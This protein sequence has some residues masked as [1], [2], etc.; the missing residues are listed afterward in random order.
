M[1]PSALYI[2]AGKDS[3]ILSGKVIR[4]LFEASPLS[5][6]LCY[7]VNLHGVVRSRTVPP[8]HPRG[9]ILPPSRRRLPG[10]GP[11]A[12]TRRTPVRHRPDTGPTP[13]AS[14]PPERSYFGSY[15]QTLIGTVG[16]QR[17]RQLPA[18]SRGRQK[19]K[20]VQHENHPPR[21]FRSR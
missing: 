1:K 10:A 3:R 16:L 14:K 9:A 21:K 8:L 17:S 2:L 13:A 18:L 15:P 5:V 12:L 6:R 19:Q 11:A 4:T 20:R 7:S